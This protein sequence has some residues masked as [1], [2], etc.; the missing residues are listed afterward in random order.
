MM[1]GLTPFWNAIIIVFLN[2]LLLFILLSYSISRHIVVLQLFINCSNSCS[3]LSS[4]VAVTKGSA[5]IIIYIIIIVK[6][7][8]VRCGDD[9][10]IN[11]RGYGRVRVTFCRWAAPTAWTRARTRRWT[12]SRHCTTAS[13]EPRA[14][15]SRRSRKG[16]GRE[17][18]STRRR[19][20]H[21]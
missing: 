2:L 18:I 17:R 15:S 13:R 3:R 14:S 20:R 9:S 7:I 11:W 6:T 16:G 1:A 8:T 5:H 10:N 12:L 19:R 21:L 4:A